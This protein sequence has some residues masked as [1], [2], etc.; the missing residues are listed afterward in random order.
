M[1]L[2]KPFILALFLILSFSSCD[3]ETEFRIIVENHSAQDITLQ[4]DTLDAQQFDSPRDS[5]FSIPQNSE[6]VIFYRM[7]RGRVT[8][9]ECPG[10]YYDYSVSMLS[11]D[12]LVKDMKGGTNWEHEYN[13]KYRIHE[14]TFVITDADLQ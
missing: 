10:F 3:L 5:V 7:N 4:V 14:C 6:R 2:F 11:G 1:N 13:P 8:E 12:T 9:Y